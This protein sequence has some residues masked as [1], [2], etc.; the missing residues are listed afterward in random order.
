VAV[1]AALVLGSAAPAYAGKSSTHGGGGGGSTTPIGND[2][3]YPQCGGSFPSG[4]AF[5]IV[6]VTGGL[7]DDANAC[8]GPDSS[9]TQ[10]ELYWAVA[11]S[12]GLSSQP[13]ASLYVNTADP[14][15]SYQGSPIL[16]WPKTGT[17]PNG[18]C[19]GTNTDACAWEY[20]YERATQDVN[21]LT[22]AASAIGTQESS[23]YVPTAPSAYHWWLDVETANTWQPDK[24]MNVADLQGMIAGFQAAGVTTIGVY[25]TSYQWGQI[26][27]T[28]NT[29]ASGS[30]YKI[31]A[32]IPGAR[33]LS[34]AE[35]NCKLTSFTGGSVVLT[36]WFSHPFDSD[37][38]C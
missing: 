23:I 30:L 14:G 29:S 19:D 33:G 11:S 26:A 38:A 4:Q 34:G 13:K 5:G 28:T 37:Y 25:S 27:G 10:S 9:Y 21:W 31:P 15:N 35:S 7:A 12:S 3:S 24:T 32:W 22:S 17:T 36:Q 16:D 8:L 18:T 20:G 6:G 2:I 1:V